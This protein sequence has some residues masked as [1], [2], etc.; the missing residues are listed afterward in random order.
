M[1]AKKALTGNSTLFCDEQGKRV[2]I[3]ECGAC[4]KDRCKKK[5]LAKKVQL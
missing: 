3:G 2:S 4:R 5:N 1:A